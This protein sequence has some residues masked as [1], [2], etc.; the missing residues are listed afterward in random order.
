MSKAT[1]RNRIVV[2][3]KIQVVINR[4]LNLSMLLFFIM[5]G[6]L[7]VVLFLFHNMDLLIMFL[8][9]MMVLS[10]LFTVV[11]F[12]IHFLMPEKIIE[13]NF[14]EYT[15]YVNSESNQ[16]QTADLLENRLH[17]LENHLSGKRI[18]LKKNSVWQLISIDEMRFQIYSN[19]VSVWDETPSSIWNSLLYSFY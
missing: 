16:L 3:T 14:K 6:A 13:L 1:M 7:S 19:P 18:Y 8:G 11:T 4:I 10:L 15:L 17:Y 2:E 5:F 9:F 12:F